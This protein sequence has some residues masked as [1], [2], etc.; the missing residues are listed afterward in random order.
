[1]AYIRK[2]KVFE[3]HRYEG[4]GKT[5]EEAYRKLFAK[6]EAAKRGE[7]VT[8]KNMTVN[9]WANTWL[10]TY[11]APRVREPGKK[12]SRGTMNEA[13]YKSKEALVY[14]YIVPAIGTVKMNDVTPVMLQRVLNGNKEMSYSHVQK[15]KLAME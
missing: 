15:L 11:I 14:N 13:S 9:T 12:K 1:M 7:L 3:G 4:C 6:I 8:S 5:E 2:T 10:D